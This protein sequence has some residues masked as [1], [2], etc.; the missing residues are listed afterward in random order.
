MQMVNL[1]PLVVYELRLAVRRPG[2]YRMR[3]A[4]GGAAIG[5]SCWGL[6]ISSNAMTASSLGHS[7]LTMLGWAGF[8][9]SV[10]AGL[11][12]TAD[13]V[14]QERREGTLGVVFFTEFGGHGGGVWQIAAQG[15]GAVFSFPAVVSSLT[16][17]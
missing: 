16:A 6:L 14:S 4:A 5:L 15:V 2:A 7:I 9:G 17:V 13:S 11:F 10:L 1:L 12:L 3:L 8:V